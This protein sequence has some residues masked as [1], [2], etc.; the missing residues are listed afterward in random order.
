MANIFGNNEVGRR[1][2][3]KFSWNNE[4][5]L[6][7]SWQFFWGIMKWGR[8][9]IMAK[10]FKFGNNEAGPVPSWEIFLGIMKRGRS[11]HGNFFLGII[12]R[13][14]SPHGKYFW[15]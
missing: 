15:E 2:Y 3:C 6:E 12:K 4:A 1:L 5:G 8:T 14:R 11:P 13:R 10:N 7:P 9:L